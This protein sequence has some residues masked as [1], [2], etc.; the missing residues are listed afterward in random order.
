MKKHISTISLL[1]LFF[2][3]PIYGQETTLQLPTSDNTGSFN[4]T[5]SNGTS[6][7]K[8]NGSGQI[9]GD[10]S[11]LAN[12]KTAVN[13]AQGNQLVKFHEGAIP[14]LNLYEA[15]VMREVTI[16]CPGPGVI[17][18]HAGG[19]LDWESREEDLVRIW[20]WP[21]PTV[22]PTYDW[23]TPDF[24]NLQIVS[25]YQCADSSDQYTSWSISKVYTVSVGGNFTVKVCG[26]KPFTSSKV[27]IGDVCMYLLYIPTGGTGPAGALVA[28]SGT[29]E[30]IE[31]DITPGNTIDGSQPFYEQEEKPTNET[32]R[33]TKLENEI[34][35]LK[36]KIN[37]LLETRTAN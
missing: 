19:Y 28:T 10:G 12:T 29:P 25:D 11:G 2:G 36:Q 15:Q 32:A 3:L 23:E 13:Y 21:H 37:L 26:D 24:H 33:I 35:E 34:D 27:R 22:S 20:F 9:S 6:V 4:V 1:V 5:N 30:I 8:V 16:N 14:G 7:F 18:A 17:I 31:P